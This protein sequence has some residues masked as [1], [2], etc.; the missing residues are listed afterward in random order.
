MDNIELLADTIKQTYCNRPEFEG[1][2]LLVDT[3]CDAA[4]HECE[5]MKSDSTI[6]DIWPRFIA[7][8]EKLVEYQPSLQEGCSRECQ[9][10]IEH[11]MQTLIAGRD[12]I[13]WVARARVPMPKSTENYIARCNALKDR[14]AVC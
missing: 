1:L 4:Q 5:T 12:L 13:N 9:Y 8:G 6:F 11:A 10:A 7:T 2:S 14:L 3:Y